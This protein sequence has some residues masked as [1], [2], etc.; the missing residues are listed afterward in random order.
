MKISPI[1]V[2]LF[3]VI[4]FIFGSCEKDE[5]EYGFIT[6]HKNYYTFSGMISS[7]DNSVLLDKNENIVICG[8]EYESI[9]VFKTTK[10][11]NTIWDKSYDFLS[12]V[13][14]NAIAEAKDESLFICGETSHDW[15]NRRSDILVMKTNHSGDTI[16]TKTFGGSDIDGGRNI[17]NTSE[18]NILIAAFTQ[19]FGAGSYGDIYLI[20]LNY[21]GDTLWTKHFPEPGEQIPFHL[22]E[23]SD[24]NYLLT[25]KHWGPH[26]EDIPD[27]MLLKIDTNGNLIWNKKYGDHRW[28]WGFSSIELSNGE[29]LTCGQLTENGYSQI[30]LCRADN[31]G[32]I[33][34]TRTYGEP[35]LTEKGYSIKK[36]KDESYTIVGTSF[37]VESSSNEI[38]LLK[39]DDS[40][41]QEWLKR[42]GTSH[43]SQGY[44][45]LKL[46][47]NTN[48]VVGNYEESIFMTRVLDN[49]KFD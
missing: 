33:Y 25:G 15:V 40:F 43:D 48:I 8:N 42:F 10:Y 20:K 46:S 44:S 32:N 5:W 39:I 28:H 9:K 27:I 47:N 49:G 16:W 18:G 22:M 12:S 21:D 26:M 19:S 1:Q 11:G 6:E 30:L 3:L 37:D 7:N 38:I 14:A 45:L 36:N 4:L 24:G 41:S 35:K 29:I 23:T 2:I 31:E 13:S 34:H 17:I